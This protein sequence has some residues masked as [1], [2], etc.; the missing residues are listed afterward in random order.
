MTL[1]SAMKDLFG[2]LAQAE[3]NCTLDN[4]CSSALGG[5]LNR[6]R[7]ELSNL[8]SMLCPTVRKEVR[9]DVR[10]IIGALEGGTH[11]TTIDIFERVVE[12]TP[13]AYTE[14]DA[15]LRRLWR[16]KDFHGVR[17]LIPVMPRNIDGLV[18]E[19]VYRYVMDESYTGDHPDGTER[20]SGTEEPS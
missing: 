11:F 20:E 16:D 12:K 6:M 17:S 2:L 7:T 3:V 13:V 8:S 4:G 18:I 1:D 5:I 14:V 10:G 19:N 9:D 15:A